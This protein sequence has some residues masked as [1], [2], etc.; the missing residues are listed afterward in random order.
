MLP[1]TGRGLRQ[2]SA[3]ILTHLFLRPCLEAPRKFGEMSEGA[4]VASLL[5]RRYWV[6]CYTVRRLVRDWEFNL[7][8]NS[9]RSFFV[10]FLYGSIWVDFGGLEII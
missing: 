3:V 8:R 7:V 1:T 5:L 9:V 6:L 10:D 4:I 2:R